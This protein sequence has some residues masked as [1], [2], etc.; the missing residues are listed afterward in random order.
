ME[1][2]TIQVK[3]SIKKKLDM[4]KIYPNES[5]G[6]VIERLTNMAI[7]EEPLSKEEI[8]DIEKSLDDIKKGKVYSLDEV[9]KDIGIK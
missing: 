2:T 4:L 5:M 1:T 9:K 3:K 7:D 8:R 6:S